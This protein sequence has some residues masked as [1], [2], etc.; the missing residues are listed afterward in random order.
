MV[1]A[2]ELLETYCPIFANTDSVVAPHLTVVMSTT[3][4]SGLSMLATN[5]RAAWVGSSTAAAQATTV[6]PRRSRHDR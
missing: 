3:A 1:N 4:L 2:Q 6:V 5:A